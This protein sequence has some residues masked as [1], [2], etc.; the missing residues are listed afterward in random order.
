MQCITWDTGDAFAGVDKMIRETFCLVFSPERQKPSPHCRRSSYNAYQDIWTGTPESSNIRKGEVP[1]L[2][3][4]KRGTN[5]A[6]TGGGEL[7]NANH[8]QTLGEKRHDRQ[9]DMEVAN[10]TK[11][12]C[13]VQDLIVNNMRPI[14]QDKSTGD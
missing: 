11:L 8:L 13:L 1:K 12:K 10:K 7:S 9:R 2:S 14:L 5:L 4:G 3:A 6:V